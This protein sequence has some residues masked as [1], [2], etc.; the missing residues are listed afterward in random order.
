MPYT[1]LR[2][3][4]A[5]A[6]HG[7]FSAAAD[8]LGVSQ[9]AVSQHVKTLEE[10]LGH[11]LITRG[12][13]RSE[14]TRDGARL[15]QAITDGLT[16]ISDVCEDIRDKHRADNKIV[17]S[18][19]PG[20]AFIWLF[21]RLMRFD[22]AHPHLSISIATDTGVDRFSTAQA[23]IGIRYGMGDNPGFLVEPLMDEDLFPVCAPALMAGSHPVHQLSDLAYHTQL[24]D[25]FTPGLQHP[26]S[27]EYWARMNDL[28]L[29]APA[30]IRRFSQSN[31]VVQAAIEG[32]GVALGRG[33]LVVDA[34]HD[35]RLV[36][37]FPH[38]ARSRLK[39]WLV[40]SES[41][42][43]M[44]GVR[45]FIDWIKSEAHQQSELVDSASNPTPDQISTAY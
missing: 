13:R 32:V 11:Q 17:I 5:M 42:R 24:R 23:D 16:G 36:R 15:A 21:P 30:R 19:S 37:P 10:W 43:S 41:V 35:G 4:E 25:E 40:Y 33:P 2:A 20:L 14:P 7:S 45:Q 27:W 9:S 28:S 39:Y 12:P 8:E 34:L 38:V 44:R 31:M 6:R 1:S 26:P 22:L 29:P 18:C 3:F